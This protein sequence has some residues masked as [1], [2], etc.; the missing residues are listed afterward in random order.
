VND[1]A[2]AIG[3]TCANDVRSRKSI[4]YRSQRKQKQAIA[5]YRDDGHSL[6]SRRETRTWGCRP[7]VAVAGVMIERLSETRSINELGILGSAIRLSTADK[8]TDVASKG[9]A[10]QVHRRTREV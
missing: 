2:P 8:L 5:S 4:H 10:A 9:T 3:G 7:Y 1:N 6:L